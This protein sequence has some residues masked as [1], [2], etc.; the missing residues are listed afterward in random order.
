MKKSLFSK[1]GAAAVVLTLVT[2]SLVGGTFAK[3]TSSVNGTAAAT[4][5]AWK[6]AFKDGADTEITESST[7]ALK[8]MK[9]DNKKADVIV[10]GDKGTLE[11]NVDGSGSEVGFTYTITINPQT[12]NVANVTFYSDE[13]CTEAL[14]EKDLTG[15][16]AYSTTESMNA[17]TTIYWMLDEDIK[18]GEDANGVAGKIL[19]YDVT[20][21]A[22]QTIPESQPSV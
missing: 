11:L 6:I 3:Y 14:A 9:T 15:K 5:A 1:V 2:A 7:I 18:V 20:I 12:E 22:D 17:T 13:N 10:P 8:P 21:T 19:N 16:V 4:V